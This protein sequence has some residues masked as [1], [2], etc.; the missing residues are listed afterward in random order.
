VIP[1]PA[2]DGLAAALIQISAHAERISG[3]DTREASHYHD[4]A[5]RLSDL[6][7][8]TAAIS[9]RTDGALARH[10]AIAELLD[11]LDRQVTALARHLADIPGDGDDPQDTRG[12][13]PVPPPRWWQLT[14]PERDT[15]LNRLRAWVS[16]IYQPG[17]GQLA[18]ILPPCWEHHPLCLYTLDWLSELWSVLYL[19]PDRTARILA[20]QGEWQTRLLTAAA[21]QMAADT[22][23]CQ[24]TTGT[25]PRQPPPPGSSPAA[26][27]GHPPR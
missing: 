16:Q 9:A 23:R 25:A 15:A 4:I 17:Y 26:S 19:D 24:H 3:L 10:A 13:L 6:A 22:T 18:A 5:A 8:E 27:P 2:G 14:G 20:A 21:D 7:T 1:D 11:G 12:Y